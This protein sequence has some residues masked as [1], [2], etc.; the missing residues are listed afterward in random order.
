MKARYVLLFFVLASSGN[1]PAQDRLDAPGPGYR[2][3][4]SPAALPDS[5]DRMPVIG[6]RTQEI[7]KRLKKLEDRVAKMEKK[8]NGAAATETPRRAEDPGDV[9]VNAYMKVQRAEKA[10]LAKDFDSAAALFKEADQLLAGIQ[11]KYPSWQPTIVRY[12]RDRVAKSLAD[13][14]KEG[15]TEEKPEVPGGGEKKR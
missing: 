3:M 5:V 10:V 2:K 9:F 6:D 14:P 4:A 11:E 8:E 7:L 13:L 1:L 12:R 15:K